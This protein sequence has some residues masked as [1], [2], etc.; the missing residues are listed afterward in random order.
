VP[1]ERYGGIEAVVALLADG[2]ADRGHDVTLFASGGSVSGARIV[3]RFAAPPSELLGRTDPD[4]DHALLAFEHRDD[5]DVLTGHCGVAGIVVGEL[6]G[7]PSLHTMHG[8]LADGTAA[9]YEN[10]MAAAPRARLASLTQ[11]QRR[12]APHLPW[13]ANLPNSIDLD[14]HVLVEDSARTY[15]AWLGRMSEEKGPDRAIQVARRAGIPIR[16]AGKMLEP[17]EQAYFEQHV[18]PLLGEDAVYVG[19]VDGD[20][21]NR[22]L[23]GARALLMPLGWDEPFGLVMIEAMACGV[24]V[25]ANRRGSVPEVIEPGRSG[26]IVEDDD[27]MVEALGQL[28]G[29]DPRDCRAAVEERFSPAAMVR[30]YE[31]ALQRVVELSRADAKTVP[32]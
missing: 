7:L 31:T 18:E 24:P 32:S 20:G 5:L 4:V 21:R 1:P 23:A 14:A 6:T 12:P 25:I 27:E 17:D 19:E 10:V 15:V 2:L 26:L 28:D 11:A 3:E 13:S 29:F 22:L 30:R 9:L 16:L 8:T